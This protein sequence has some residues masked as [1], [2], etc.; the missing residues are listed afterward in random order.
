MHWGLHLLRVCPI[1]LGAVMYAFHAIIS[2]MSVS[3]WTSP[4]HCTV[5]GVRWSTYPDTGPWGLSLP[6]E[7]VLTWSGLWWTAGCHLH[8]T[9]R[10]A[11][12][13]RYLEAVT[14]WLHQPADSRWHLLL[15]GWSMC[16][17]DAATM[18]AL[19][20]RHV[21]Y[22]VGVAI[23]GRGDGLLVA[24]HPESGAASALWE[25]CID[26][27]PA[28]G[29]CHRALYVSEHPISEIPLRHTLLALPPPLHMPRYMPVCLM[30]PALFCC[31]V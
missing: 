15:G 8:S 11:L 16:G 28:R 9:Q 4:V 3:T 24:L 23:I 18:W 7:V 20:I 1:V 19:L 13:A 29:H 31:S 5:A 25:V 21:M 17:G 26:T 30:P 14:R 27:P 22:P 2:T 6:T 12:M 10:Q